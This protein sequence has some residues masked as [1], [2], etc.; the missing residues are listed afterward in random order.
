MK[1][2]PRN[3]YLSENIDENTAQQLRREIVEINESDRNFNKL[4]LMN[5]YGLYK[6]KPIN[7]YI[8][9]CGGSVDATLAI[10]DLIELSQTPVHTIVNGR[11]YSGAFIVA[12]S[13]KVRYATKNSNYMLHQMSYEIRGTLKEVDE[14]QTVANRIQKKLLKIVTDKTNISKSQLDEMVI[15][16]LD[17]YIETADAK[18]LN[19]FDHY[20]EQI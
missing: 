1:P 19:V 16:K 15:K 4:F 20:L 17:W 13:G 8:D 3:L 7:L 14:F 9:S 10:V 18:Y 6:P 2:L 12:I 11:A 5:E